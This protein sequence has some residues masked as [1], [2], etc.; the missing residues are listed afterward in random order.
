MQAGS[1]GLPLIIAGCVSMKSECHVTVAESV[2]EA[3]KNK[4]G[5]QLDKKNFVKGNV[6][7]DHS[8]SFLYVRHNLESTFDMVTESL[9]LLTRRLVNGVSF[10]ECCFELGMVCH[11]ITDYFSLAHNQCFSGG[12][13]KHV[14]YE[15]EQERLTPFFLGFVMEKTFDHREQ[16]CASLSELASLI[17]KRHRQYLKEADKSYMTDF[18]YAI[19]TC[20]EVVLSVFAI[21][22]RG[23]DEC[24]KL[25]S[26]L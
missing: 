17:L 2:L 10:G 24:R 19:A 6:K 25:C 20:C 23:E 8:F 11:Y 15:R 9:L 18:Y 14:K 5:T 7:P 3:L 13:R 12:L 16:S 21:A 26:E 1:V 22:K 4:Y